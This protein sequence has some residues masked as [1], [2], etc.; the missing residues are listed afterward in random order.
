[1]VL[2]QFSNIEGVDW[3]FFNS[4]YELEKETV[5]WMATLLPVKT[6]GPTIPSMYLDIN[7]DKDDNRYGFSLYKQDQDSCVEWLDTKVARSVVYVSFGSMAELGSEQMEELAHG[8]IGC[9]KPFIWVVRASEE[10]NLPINF[11]NMVV[12]GSDKIE[13][14]AHLPPHRVRCGNAFV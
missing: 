6:I 4:V 13:E 12:L 2:N 14:Q 3:V 7:H 1:M 8:L 9:G 10:S 11:S 5:D